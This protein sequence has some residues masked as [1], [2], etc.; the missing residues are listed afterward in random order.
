M[1]KPSYSFS[2]LDIYNKCPWAYKL[3]YLDKIPR[4]T[5]E[6][7]VIGQTMHKLIAD[8]LVRLI[9]QN[10]QTDWE[11]AEKVT[12]FNGFED[13]AYMWPRFYNNFVMPTNVKDQV[14]ERQL[15]FNRQWQ[16]VDWFA[17]DAWFRMV[18]DWCFL[19]DDLAVVVDWKTNR[20]LPETVEKD[21]QLQI[22]G[23]G[24][25]HLFPQSEE[26]LLRLHF[27]RYGAEREII[28]TPDDLKGV[29]EAVQERIA[30]I[31]ADQHY[32]PKPGSFCSWC[33]VQA[34]CPVM[35][36][37]LIPVETILPATREQAEKSA[38]LLLALREIGRELTANLKQWVIA[39]GPIWVGDVFYGPN[40]EISYEFNPEQL[41]TFLLDEGLSRDQVWELVTMTKT[42]MERELRK[43]KRKELIDKVYGMAAEK[44]SESFDFHKTPKI[45]ETYACEHCGTKRLISRPQA[46]TKEEG[47]PKHMYCRTC[48]DITKHLRI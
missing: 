10:Q 16:P 7:L 28:L 30:T 43:A 20:I 12:P 47:H 32:D 5:S 17:A 27:L 46:K 21:L 13:I 2:R 34:H 33:G 15:A 14:V 8:Y 31:E 3:V 41:T 39:N 11:W 38:T 24:V 48:D 45:I 29:P 1:K 25:R 19:Q 26:V 23:W 35:A 44:V 42:T 18:M 22:Y 37:A 36:K 9:C 6:A 4:Q 40:P